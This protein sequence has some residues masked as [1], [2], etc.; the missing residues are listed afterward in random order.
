[1]FGKVIVFGL[2]EMIQKKISEDRVPGSEFGLR[3]GSGMA[4]RAVT[5][6]LWDMRADR[7]ITAPPMEG[8]M[9]FRDPYMQWYRRIT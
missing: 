2:F 1:M 9:D 6:A 5:I 8:I 7:I 4:A 3:V